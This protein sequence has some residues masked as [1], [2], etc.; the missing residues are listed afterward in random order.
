[1]IAI[2]PNVNDDGI[3]SVDLAYVQAIQKAGGVP[4]VLPI[5]ED[6][7]NILVLLKKSDGVLLTGGGDVDPKYY[8]EAPHEKT[9]KPSVLRDEFDFFCFNSAFRLKKPIFA[10]CRGLQLANVALG[11]T[12][13]QDLPS[14]FESSLSHKQSEGKFEQSHVVALTEPLRSF[15]GKEKM[16]A[17][18]F[19]HQAIKKLADGLE[20]TARTE[21]GLIEAVCAKGDRY[22][23]GYQWH[24]E[25]L[26]GFD[27]DNLKLFEEFIKACE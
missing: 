23:R 19:H 27:K 4:F 12:L 5:T 9:E 13:Y 22:L 15:I 6:K 10:I 1:M 14:Q 21:D 2:T 17:N 11:G 3:T 26:C 24:P 8:G 20:V 18:S 16:A 7:E 25:R